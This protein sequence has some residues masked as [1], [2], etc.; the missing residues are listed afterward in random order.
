MGEKQPRELV[1][2]TSIGSN[3]SPPADAF[4][5][6]LCQGDC[7]RDADCDEGLICFQRGPNV[8]VPG[9]EGGASESSQTD[10]CIFDFS[11]AGAGTPQPTPGPTPRPTTAQ[12]TTT[13]GMPSQS[14]SQVPSEAP[15]QGPFGRIEYVGNEGTFYSAY[16]MPVCKG[17]CDVDDDC[18]EGLYCHQRGSMDAVPYCDG[19]EEERSTADFCAWDGESPVPVPVSDPP[20]GYFRLKLYWEEGYHW[21]NET[22]E[23]EWCMMYDYQGYPGTGLCWVGDDAVNC[24]QDQVYVGK[25]IQDERM[26]FTFVN[27]SDAPVEISKQPSFIDERLIMTGDNERC[28][29]RY[30]REIWLESCDP[31]NFRQRWIALNGNFDGEEF[32][33]SQRGFTHQCVTNDHHP[34]SG[35]VVELHDCEASR[36]YDSQTSFWNLY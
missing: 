33:I 1:R 13:T 27:V 22:F 25:C 2:V 31:D 8:P 20:E 36:A 3:G 6:Q 19:G 23:R 18:I 9:C 26:W 17:D 16:P 35:E 10:F 34:K 14:P 7:D 21:Q 32:E 24:D 15:S 5:L 11:S 12:P 4:P 30:D 29:T 28:L